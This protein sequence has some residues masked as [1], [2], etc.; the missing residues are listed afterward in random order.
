MISLIPTFPYCGKACRFAVAVL[1]VALAS[2]FWACDSSTD[3]GP[4]P[5]IKIESPANG[6]TVTGPS[7]LL[8][9]KTTGFAFVA[10]KI[11]AAQHIDSVSDG[12]IHVY[13]D[14]PA[15]TDA[16]AVAVLT[17]A[18]TVTLN[19]P[20]AGWHYIIVQGASEAHDDVPG[21]SDSV[22]FMVNLP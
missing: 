6:G 3:S 11:A 20:T 12:H 14:K 10:A 18:D 4:T 1:T 8:Q 9:V 19:I 5:T 17:K 13:L 2:G 16:D 22:K 21:M 15:T 7:V